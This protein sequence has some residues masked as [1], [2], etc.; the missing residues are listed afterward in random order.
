MSLKELKD[1]A[2]KLRD[3]GY[4][5]QINHYEDGDGDETTITIKTDKKR[6][7]GKELYG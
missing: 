7:R 2:E 1:Y 6:N 3:K 5:V 4:N